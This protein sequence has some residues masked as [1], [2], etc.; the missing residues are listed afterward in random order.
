[1]NEEDRVKEIF[2]EELEIDESLWD[3]ELTF[4]HLAVDSLTFVEL[5][6]ALEQAFDIELD[7]DAMAACQTVGEAVDM[8]M[9]SLG[10]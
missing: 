4:D 3:R 10:A 9:A 8:V 2:M 5:V 6:V 1:M 7:D